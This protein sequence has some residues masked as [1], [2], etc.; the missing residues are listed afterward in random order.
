MPFDEKQD[1]YT[2]TMATQAL[3]IAEEI[4]KLPAKMLIL[5]ADK[6]AKLDAIARKALKLETEKPT[7]IVAV[8]FL[9]A[10]AEPRLIRSH[11][12]A[13]PG[14]CLAEQTGSDPVA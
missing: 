13:E 14:V 5:H 10:P 6:L 3:R 7:S 11:V 1:R 4:K 9:A 2:E 12:A 8:A